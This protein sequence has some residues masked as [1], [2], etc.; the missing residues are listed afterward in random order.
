M[1]GEEDAGRLAFSKESNS[2]TDKPTENLAGQ[3]SGLVEQPQIAQ[4]P[5]ANPLQANLQPT[6]GEV[7]EAQQQIN[8]WLAAAGNT[9]DGD[10]IDEKTKRPLKLGVLMA[11]QTISNSTQNVNFGGGL[12]SEI[13][14]SKRLRLDVGV[15][16]AKQNLVPDQNNG[17]SLLMADVAGIESSKANSFASNY[18]N[19]SSE[20]SFGQVEIP[21]NM[22]YSVIQRKSADFYLVSG[23]SN[24]F[25]LNQEKTTTFNSVAFGAN[26]TNNGT[27]SLSSRSISESPADTGGQMDI[28]Q[29]INL[30]MGFEQ[31]LKN[32]TSISF[33]P[34][35]KFTIGDQTFANQRF[36]IGGINL[37]MNFQLKK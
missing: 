20:L 2:R 27:Q 11:P 23:L 30:G 24:M 32:G 29:L 28:G 6:I 17:G 15:G 12:M 8:A 16:Y 37:R 33:E 9:E 35:Y 10:K 4:L 34:F 7:E 21:L 25:Y 1:P 31:N 36:A 26:A 19:S 3:S 18:I 5:P 14:F 22:K 13:A